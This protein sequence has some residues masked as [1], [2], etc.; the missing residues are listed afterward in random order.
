MTRNLSGN[1]VSN[2]GP[3]WSSCLLFCG[4]ARGKISSDE[5]WQVVGMS[6][7]GK[8]S[9]YIATEFEVNPFVAVRLL[10]KY[11]ATGDVSE[12]TTKETVR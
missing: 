12:H 5:N 8:S 3:S 4:A 7:D 11:R 6:R 10:Q 9:R 1:Q 2:T